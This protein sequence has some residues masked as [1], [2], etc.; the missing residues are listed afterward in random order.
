[1]L[2]V[3]GQA[4]LMAVAVVGLVLLAVSAMVWVGTQKRAAVGAMATGLV[5]ALGAVATDY[6]WITP[7]EQVADTL[8]RLAKAL[9]QNEPERVVEFLAADSESLRKEVL[10]RLR[11][12]RVESVS[13]KS[14]LNV[15]VGVGRP[16]RT[17]ESQFNA[18]AVVRDGRGSGD[19]YTVPRFFVVRWVHEDEGWRVASYT[20]EEP[21]GRRLPGTR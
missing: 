16:P 6:L 14:N 8:H 7:A 18:V 1:M 13:I 12:I 2:V 19:S 5:I 3:F 9:E 11:S 15:T 17:A 21:L 10:G 20:M 4:E